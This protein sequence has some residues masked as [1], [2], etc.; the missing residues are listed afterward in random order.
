MKTFKVEEGNSAL[1]E[2]AVV[3]TIKGVEEF[4]PLKFLQYAR[5]NMTSVLK[6]NRGTKVKLVLICKM[7]RLGNYEGVIQ[8]CACHS[9]IEVNLDGTD[10]KEL[11]DLMIEIILE[12]IATFQSMGSMRRF[13]SVIRL[14]LHT[15]KYKPLKGETYIPLPKELAVK[16]AIIN[17][18]NKDNKCFYGRSP[19]VIPE[20]L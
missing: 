2:F 18:K 20:G 7:E 1:E 14:E 10:E 12:K 16:T 4:D 6:N 11:Y 5:Q 8:P 15:M 9:I 3:Y 19:G 17:M 13:H